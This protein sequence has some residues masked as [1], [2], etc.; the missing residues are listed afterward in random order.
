MPAMSVVAAAESGSRLD[1]LVSMRSI[2]ARAVGDEDTPPRDLAALTRRLMDIARE[3]EA[4][5]SGEEGEGDGPE[6]DEA[7]DPEAI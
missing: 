1:L 7:W 5:E 6:P 2:V 3:I 4:I